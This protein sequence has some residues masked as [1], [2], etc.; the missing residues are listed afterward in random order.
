M[1]ILETMVAIVGLLGIVVGFMF[2]RKVAVGQTAVVR[3]WLRREAALSRQYRDLFENARDAILIHEAESGVVLDC[4]RQACELYG[5]TRNDLVGAGLNTLT[6]E[7]GGYE[8]QIGRL[9]QGDSS[10]AFTTLHS[11]SDGRSISV[12]VSLSHVEYAGKTAVLSFNR[13]VTAQVEVAEA[14][15]RRG[16]ILEAIA[17]AAEKLLSGDNWEANIQSVLEHLGQ[18]LSVSRAYIFRNHT[19]PNGEPLTSQAY[20]WVAPGIS[21]QIHNPELQNFSWDGQ[22]QREVDGRFAAGENR[23]GNRGRASGI[24]PKASARKGHQIHYCGTD[25]GGR[26]LVG[27]YRL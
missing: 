3:E 7:I 20:E 10:S 19:G 6:K 27:L 15:R 17:F 13:D 18:S 22:R 8:E 5:W 9:K 1:S 23:P 25:L 11:R 26:N 21:S 16:A 12:Q 2:Y 14:L 24:G 4:N